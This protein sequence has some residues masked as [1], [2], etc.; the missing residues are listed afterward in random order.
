V[1]IIG[2]ARERGLEFS[3]QDLLSTD[4]GALARVTR[5][6]GWDKEKGTA[7]FELVGEEVR[8][9]LAEDVEDAFPLSR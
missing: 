7:A 9:R 6:E 4:G 1:R 8:S 5:R 3:V 2:R